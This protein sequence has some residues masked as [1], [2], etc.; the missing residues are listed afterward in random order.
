M[1][2]QSQQLEA[3]RQQEQAKTNRQPGTGMFEELYAKEVGKQESSVGMER[4]AAPPPGA[5]TYGAGSVAAMTAVSGVGQETS[6]TKVMDNI[7]TLLG[8]LDDYSQQLGGSQAGGLKQAYGVLENISSQVR[9][10]K[11]SMPAELKDQH[12]G[13]SSMVDELEV[14]TVTEQMKFNRGDY[15]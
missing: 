8:Q 2:I 7:E 13:L 12:P 1:K 11:G 15:L 9:D 5:R 3:L 4:P 10:L 14:M 6:A